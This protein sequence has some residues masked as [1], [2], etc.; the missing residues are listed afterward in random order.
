MNFE[1]R[2]MV[3]FMIFLHSVLGERDEGIQF[4]N[5]ILSGQA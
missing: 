2:K 4:N 5:D 1:I 3:I